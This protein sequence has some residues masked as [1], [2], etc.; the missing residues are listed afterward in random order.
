[1]LKICYGLPSAPRRNGARSLRRDE[2]VPTP[3]CNRSAFS[4]HCR[5]DLEASPSPLLLL[6]WHRAA[7]P[8]WPP[9]RLLNSCDGVRDGSKPYP[10]PGALRTLQPM[11]PEPHRLST[12]LPQLGSSPG[13]RGWRSPLRT[14]SLRDFAASVCRWASLGETVAFAC[15]Q[16]PTLPASRVKV[17][18]LMR[19]K[20]R[21]RRP[22]INARRL[23]IR[24]CPRPN[25]PLRWHIALLRRS[26]GSRVRR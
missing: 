5:S 4:S 6:H 12:S 23:R 2:S 19:Q 13:C 1:M 11:L 14:I 20:T 15:A 22:S 16:F 17:A 26:S 9:K 10:G 8:R 21:W 25:V 3:V 24:R 18:W 7:P